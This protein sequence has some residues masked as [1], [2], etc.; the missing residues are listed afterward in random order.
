VPG[1]VFLC[2]L[3]G[4]GKST[5]APILAGLLGAD[6]LDTDAMVV[7]E[8]GIPV[9]E[10]FAR[11]GE[12]GFREREA[13]AV[14]SAC[15]RSGAVVALGGGALERDDTFERIRGEGVLVFLD[16]PEPVLKTRLSSGA[17]EIRPLLKDPDALARLRERRIAR[18]RTASI[19]VDTASLSPYQVA[20][21]IQR[22]IL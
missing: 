1:N 11:E 21:E 4:S 17:G 22:S 19:V 2:G 3:S 8:A 13:R 10:I 15:A 14:A 5:V 16:A 6:A 7:A 18:F 20:V 12:A 9:A